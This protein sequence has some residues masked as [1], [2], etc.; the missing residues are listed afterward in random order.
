VNPGGWTIQVRS[1]LLPENWTKNTAIFENIK[2][3]GKGA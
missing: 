1:D 2:V 3:P